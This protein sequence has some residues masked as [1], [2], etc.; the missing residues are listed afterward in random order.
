MGSSAAHC[1]GRRLCRSHPLGRRTLLRGVSGL[2]L[3]SRLVAATAAPDAAAVSQNGWSAGSSVPLTMLEVGAAEL[4]P[5]VRSGN[6]HTILGYV[7]RRF[8]SEVKALVRGWCWGYAYHP[9]SGSTTYS[10]HAS[11]TAIDCNAPDHPLG[12]ANTFTVA[13][14]ALVAGRW[15]AGEIPAIA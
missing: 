8:N 5:G 7:A 15:S 1:S 10:N 11:G 3:G 6:V 12:V 14:V 13:Q 2:V 4:A 9:I